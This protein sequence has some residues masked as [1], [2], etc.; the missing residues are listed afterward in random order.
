MFRRR[1][2]T[3]TVVSS[4]KRR[5]ICRELLGKRQLVRK[6]ATDAEIA[7]HVELPKLG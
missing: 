7:V 6:E 5:V 3:W 1:E 2:P 4:A